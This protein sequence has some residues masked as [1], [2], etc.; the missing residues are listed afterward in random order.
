M[1]IYHSMN[2]KITLIIPIY[3]E[4]ES[5]FSLI[6]EITE[7]FRNYFTEVL[8]IDDGSS[9]NFKKKFKF[10]KIKNIV[11][12]CIHLEKN[13][14]KCFAMMAGVKNSKNNLICVLDGDGQNPPKEARKMIDFWCKKKRTKYTLLCG[15]RVDR[16][17]NFKKKISSKI[18]NSVRKFLLN[19]DCSDTACALKVFN[20]LDYLEL[21]YYRNMH[22]FL[23]ALFKSNSGNIINIKVHDRKRKSGISKFNFNNRFWVGIIDLIR[24][25]YLINFN[26]EK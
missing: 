16:Q 11:I 8:I 24:F 5:I 17:D 9:D 25:W 21:K 18:A 7:E 4:E 22:R 6:D 12:K 1:Y 20:K 3:N 26:K 15:H 23:P 19:D 13:M 14:G 10:K 2:K